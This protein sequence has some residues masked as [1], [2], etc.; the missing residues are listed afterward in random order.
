MNRFLA[1]ALL[2][3]VSMFGKLPAALAH[4]HHTANVCSTSAPDICAHL[5]FENEPNTTDESEFMLHFMPKSVSPALVTNV[6][7][8]L[9]MDEMGHGS[10]PVTL[11]AVDDA[12]YN[13]SKAYFVMSGPW[14]VK[15]SFDYAGATHEISIPVDV[16]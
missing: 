12:H 2:A 15:V 10:S 6:S 7:V 4:S 11:T 14:Q 5:G 3:A 1:L 13:V 9:W 8:K 16:K